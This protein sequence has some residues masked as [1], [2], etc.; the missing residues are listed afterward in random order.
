MKRLLKVIAVGIIVS[1][2][3]LGKN[4]EL[5][6][7]E[8]KQWISNL[9][10][11]FD[12]ALIVTDVQAVMDDWRNWPKSRKMRDFNGNVYLM[13]FEIFQQRTINETDDPRNTIFEYRPITIDLNGDN[14]PDLM[15]SKMTSD[16]SEYSKRFTVGGAHNLNGSINL[17][18]F[19]AIKRGSGYQVVYKCIHTNYGY[20]V[21]EYYYYGDCADM[22]YT[23]SE[24]PHI[25]SIQ[26]YFYANSA[27]WNGSTSVM[28]TIRF[29][30]YYTP[31]NPI[32]LN[33]TSSQIRQYMPELMDMNGDGL[34]DVILSTSV[35][36]RYRAITS[37]NYFLDTWT[38]FE[39][40]IHFILYNTGNGFTPGPMCTDSSIGL[41]QGLKCR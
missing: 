20:G 16:G 25:W 4:A 22:S 19:V 9:L 31:R 15:Y 10:S 8:T 34:S 14:L 37:D 27:G 26:Q 39:T 12:E 17:M 21:Q 33:T 29:N 41:P 24:N 13:P 30:G 32:Y 35:K 23:G 1:S 38:G 36:G 7:G 40:G 18:Q 5:F 11:F 3:I 2:L 6:T 28:D